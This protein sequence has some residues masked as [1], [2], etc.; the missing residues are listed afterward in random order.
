[1]VRCGGFGDRVL[2]G[3]NGSGQAGD[4][5]KNPAYRPVTVVGL[6]TR[7]A[8]VRTTHDATCVLL[9]SGEIYCFGNNYHGQL[10]NGVMRKSSLVPV[11][12]S[13]P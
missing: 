7:A 6:P 1:M 12:V 5:T 3:E 4:G 2:P 8:Q 9:T 11:K 10:G 13:L